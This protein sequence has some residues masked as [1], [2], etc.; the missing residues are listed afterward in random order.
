MWLA[1]VLGQLG[2]LLRSFGAKLE[3]AGIRLVY[4][5]L[6]ELQLSVQALPVGD[7]HGEIVDVVLYD[8]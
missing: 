2:R 1:I 4:V 6:G 8:D 3:C 5:L 7:L